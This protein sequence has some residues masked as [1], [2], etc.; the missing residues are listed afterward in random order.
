MKEPTIE[1]SWVSPST[2]EPR[3]LEMTEDQAAEFWAAACYP[4]QCTARIRSI[5]PAVQPE[6]AE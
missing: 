6:D 3:R 2:G 1:I 4:V 5:S